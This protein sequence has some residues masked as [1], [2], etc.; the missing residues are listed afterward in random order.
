MVN[1]LT[2]NFSASIIRISDTL[3]ALFWWRGMLL[4]LRQRRLVPG[5]S[6]SSEDM[7]TPWHFYAISKVF[8]PFIHEVISLPE[9]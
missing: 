7:A 9:Y 3:Q 8:Q 4:C 6:L 5:E 2:S 1:F